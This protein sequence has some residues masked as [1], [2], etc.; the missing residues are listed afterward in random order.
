MTSVHLK[1]KGLVPGPRDGARDPLRTTPDITRHPAGQGHARQV[2]T[3]MTREGGE[4]RHHLECRASIAMTYSLFD[5]TGLQATIIFTVYSY[6]Q[7]V[8]LLRGESVPTIC[9]RYS[10]QA[11]S[12]TRSR[13]RVP[14]ESAC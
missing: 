7:A 11:N 2:L 1:G 12:F 10:K 8:A 6:P 13:R 9:Q 4:T 3:A 14:V 5:V